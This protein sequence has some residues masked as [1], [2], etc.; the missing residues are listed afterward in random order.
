MQSSA[1]LT[2]AA[3]P[4]I[5]CHFCYKLS[6]DSFRS[7]IIPAYLPVDMNTFTIAVQCSFPYSY[8]VQVGCEQFMS[9][10]L[11]NR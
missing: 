7:D 8:T 11:A 5:P 6:N 4:L 2:K 3:L 1:C 10:D 9:Y